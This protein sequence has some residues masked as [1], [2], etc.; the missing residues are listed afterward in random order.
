VLATDGLPVNDHSLAMAL[1]VHVQRAHLWR[2]VV[3]SSGAAQ[4]IP[5]LCSMSSMYRCIDVSMYLCIYASMYLLYMYLCT[6]TYITY[7]YVYIWMYCVYIIH[8]W[9]YGVRTCMI[10]SAHLT[11]SSD[12][13][14]RAKV[15][16]NSRSSSDS[17][18]SHTRHFIYNTYM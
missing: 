18:C 6:Y 4:K 11:A 14:S 10:R 8:I 1:Q 13:S 3:V 9:M 5:C 7:I 12:S 15:K 17:D 16:S 2:S